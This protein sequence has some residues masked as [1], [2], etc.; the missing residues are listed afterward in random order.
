KEQEAAKAAETLRFLQSEQHRGTFTEHLATLGLGVERYRCLDDLKQ[1]FDE[2]KKLDAASELDTSSPL[3]GVASAI[4]S[5]A[6]QPA[7][8]AG[9]RVPPAEDRP[10]P[11][12]PGTVPLAATPVNIHLGSMRPQWITAADGTQTLVLVRAVRIDNKTVYQGVILDWA[13]LQLVLK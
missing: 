12:L 9:G 6:A 5:G 4:C 10:Q 7:G 2:S 11:T 3:L 1:A 13:K 8:T